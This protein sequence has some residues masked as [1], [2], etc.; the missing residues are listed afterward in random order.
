MSDPKRRSLLSQALELEDEEEQPGSVLQQALGMSEP[1]NDYPAF[2]DYKPPPGPAGQQPGA[3]G[4]AS[5]NSEPTSM[6]EEYLNENNRGTMADAKAS[7]DAILDTIRPRALGMG[8]MQPEPEMEEYAR[9]KAEDARKNQPGAAMATNLG[10][11]VAEGAMGMGMSGAFGLGPAAAGAMQ[12]GL[13]TREDGGTLGQTASSAAGGAFFGAMGGAAGGAI[14][15]SM[16]AAA[17]YAPELARKANINR[18]AAS[19]VYGSDLAA[20]EANKGADYVQQLGRD[21]ESKGLH[22]GSGPLGFLPQPPETYGRNAAAL[23]ADAGS[24]MGQAENQVAGLEY[25][26]LVDTTGLQNQMRSRADEASGMWDSA[27]ANEA[28]ARNALADNIQNKAGDAASWGDALEQKRYFD[29]QI[30]W[31]RT[32]GISNSPMD[33]QIRR[34]AAGNMR[35][36]LQDSLQGGVQEG[37]VPRELADQ[38][39]GANKDFAVGAAVTD[40]AMLRVY[41]EY[42]NQPI[43]LGALAASAGNPGTAAAGQLVKYRGRSAMAGTQRALGGAAADYGNSDKLA[44]MAEYLQGAPM[45]TAAGAAGDAIGG[46]SRAQQEQAQSER[47]RQATLEGRGQ[48]LP[49][50][51]NDVLVSQPEALGPY[52]ADFE[53]AGRTPGAIASLLA[54][55]QHDRVWRTQYLPNFQGAQ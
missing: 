11:D 19:G 25:Q 36:G 7:G 1:A 6:F 26:P 55:L 41:R 23:R 27:G 30:D 35:A 15:R 53:Q 34:E 29:K 43:S 47:Q 18:V 28:T 46:P 9:L 42:G 14:D 5:Q 40:P 4:V 20:M 3:A 22:R 13:H 50:T 17:N 21:I 16:S 24:R 32:G 37:T 38:W 12:A 8:G 44:T 2:I 31:G 48:N 54:K 10:L 45:A 51:I 33:E 39:T 49:Q 52:R